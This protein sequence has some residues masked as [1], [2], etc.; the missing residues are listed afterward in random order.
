MRSFKN[1]YLEIRHHHDH[2]L[3]FLNSSIA[4]IDINNVLKRLEKKGE[5]SYDKFL[6]EWEHSYI[7]NIKIDK[8][9]ID[10]LCGRLA[11]KRAVRRHLLKN[12]GTGPAEGKEYSLFKDI[13]IRRTVTGRPAVFIK[14]GHGRNGSSEFFISISHTDGVAA[15][16]VSNKKNCKGIG[17]D[18]EK[19]E[20]RNSSLLDVAFTDDEKSKLMRH[21]FKGN[22]KGNTILE[23][24]IARYWSIKEAVMKSMG[25]GVNIDLK[26][27]EIIDTFEYSA[28]VQL[29]NDALARFNLLEGIDVKAESTRIEN[30]MVSI[31]CLY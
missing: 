18:I 22:G 5:H 12:S 21:S 8:R 1:T 16:L 13:E 28:D 25:V 4:F 27:I 19:I 17:I 3:K 9:R 24:E 10:F 6:T 7:E 29:K 31:A 2:T 15:S 26:S 14:D 20:S 11:G 30:F 23:E